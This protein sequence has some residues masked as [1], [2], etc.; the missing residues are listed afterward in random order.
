MRQPECD[1]VAL[2]FQ[3]PDVEFSFSSISL[4]ES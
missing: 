1:L 4:Q 3:E 2:V